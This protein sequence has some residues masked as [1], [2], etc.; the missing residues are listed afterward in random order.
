MSAD[1]IIESNRGGDKTSSALVDAADKRIVCIEEPLANATLDNALCKELTGGGFMNLRTLYGKPFE[2]KFKAT[3][4]IATNSLMV[5]VAQVGPA[6]IKRMKT[7]EMRSQ[8]VENPDNSGTRFKI[9][10]TLICKFERPDYRCAMWHL[11]A[12]HWHKQMQEGF[13]TL[14]QMEYLHAECFDM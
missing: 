6:E 5:F 3:M 8:F 7:I 2:Q 1:A 13:L 11:L 9:D 14:D 4:F 10:H 12:R